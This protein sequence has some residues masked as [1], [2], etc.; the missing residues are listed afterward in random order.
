MIFRRLFP[1]HLRKPGALFERLHNSAVVWSWIFNGIR[2]VSGIVL[3]PLV[4]RELSTADL[5]MYYVL[6]SLAAL[7][8]IIDFGF[9]PTVGRFVSYAMGGAE[10]LQAH[11][12]GMSATS[13]LPNYPLLWELLQA[14]RIL[15]RYLSL[16]V[17]VVLGPWGTYLVEL[18]I[19]ETSS[20]LITRLAWA[21]TWPPRCLTFIGTGGRLI[22]SA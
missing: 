17:F 7:A 5:G 21:V 13:S 10:T 15:Y 22:W 2:L 3:L 16:V 19:S 4:L 14:T 18:R 11:G 8:P 1:A 20:T 12:V 6:L 9:G